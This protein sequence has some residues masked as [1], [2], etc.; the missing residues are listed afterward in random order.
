[1]DFIDYEERVEKTCQIKNVLIFQ[2][3]VFV[4]KNKY[5]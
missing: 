3:V 4:M 2:N 5:I 1:M